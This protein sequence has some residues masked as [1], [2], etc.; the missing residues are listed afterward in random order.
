MTAA[1][2]FVDIQT[3][4]RPIGPALVRTP[5]RH[6]RTLSS[7]AGCEVWLKFENR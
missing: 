2:T 3:A 4:A 1:P 5:T 7:I 6:S